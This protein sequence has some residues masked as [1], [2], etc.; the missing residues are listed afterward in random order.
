MKLGTVTRI[1]MLKTMVAFILVCKLQDTPKNRPEV[2]ENDLGVTKIF[3]NLFVSMHGI[4]YMLKFEHVLS[5]PHP[6]NMSMS[7]VSKGDQQFSYFVFEKCA[8]W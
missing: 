7:M 4:S 1:L 8:I 6:L 5:I 2:A 3:Y